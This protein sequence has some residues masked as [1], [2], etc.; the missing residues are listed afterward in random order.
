MYEYGNEVASGR[1]AVTRL[2]IFN[3]GPA[4]NSTMKGLERGRTVALR[5]ARAEKR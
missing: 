5:V 3:S 2:G 1:V 4:P